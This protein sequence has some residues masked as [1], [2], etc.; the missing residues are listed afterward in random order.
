MPNY[1][2]NGNLAIGIHVMEWAEFK[3]TFGYNETRNGILV[4]MA[5]ALAALKKHGCLRVFMD[6][7]FVTTK[8]EPGDF[9]GCWN[10]D[11]V[12]I[13]EL[14]KE[15]SCFMDL[16]AP[17]N[18]QKTLFKG[19]I[20]PSTVPADNKGSTFLEFFQKDRDETPKGI[21]QINLNSFV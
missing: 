11:G 16:R 15:L 4:G 13:A 20:F 10:P 2:P 14:I 3:E 21:I 1:Q 9:D 6:G 17:R 19:E 18:S 5:I 12:N 8:E 7:S